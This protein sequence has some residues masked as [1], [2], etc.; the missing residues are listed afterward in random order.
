MSDRRGAKRRAPTLSGAEGELDLLRLHMD[1]QANAPSLARG[2]DPLFATWDGSTV[3]PDVSGE[4][5]ES[6]AA[7]SADAESVV[8]SEGKLHRPCATCRSARVLCDRGHPC[9]RCIRLNLAAT[10]AA[11]PTVKR[12][13][14]PKDV[15]QARLEM[16]AADLLATGL[17]GGSSSSYPPAGQPPI[18]SATVAQVLPT[19]IAE[20]VAQPAMPAPIAQQPAFAQPVLQAPLLP[21]PPSLHAASSS[22]ST[23][24]SSNPSPPLPPHQ[25]GS[26]ALEGEG[27][28]AAVVVGG[29]PVLSAA[30]HTAP[31]DV[32]AG[33]DPQAHADRLKIAALRRQLLEL[34][35]DPCV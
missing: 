24:L 21:R 18:A 13:R 8:D 16:L 34:G 35:I 25:P 7:G 6:S 29:T 9:R 32:S 3:F 20:P 26:I 28:A 33:E 27:V 11:P 14:P 30:P 5:G 4:V 2:R 15:A 12:G 22:G 10:C 31:T 23:V 17:P 1:S 19:T